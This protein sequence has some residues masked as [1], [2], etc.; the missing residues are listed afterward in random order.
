MPQLRAARIDT[1]RVTFRLRE[2]VSLPAA[3]GRAAH[4]ALTLP[5]FAAT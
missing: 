2:L 1:R 3:A 4:S 5:T